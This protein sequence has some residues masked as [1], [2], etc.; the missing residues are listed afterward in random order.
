MEGAAQCSQATVHFAIALAEQQA[1]PIL[2]PGQ[3]QECGDVR[4]EELETNKQR[5]SS[6]LNHKEITNPNWHLLSLLIFLTLILIFKT[7]AD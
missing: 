4:G 7:K 1:L 2:G 5:T 6:R 3:P